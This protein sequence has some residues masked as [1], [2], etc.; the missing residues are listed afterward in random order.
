MSDIDDHSLNSGIDEGRD[1]DFDTE[2]VE[3]DALSEQEIK[4]L[5]G[6][7]EEQPFTD[8]TS[9]DEKPKKD[10]LKSRKKAQKG[11]QKA[12]RKKE[13]PVQTDAEHLTEETGN[14]GGL[15]DLRN[16]LP[17]NN[18]I[19]G[20]SFDISSNPDLRIDQEPDKKK[21]VTGSD[22]NLNVKAPVKH[23]ADTMTE[24]VRYEG[25]QVLPSSDNPDFDS[26]M[27]EEIIQPERH[28]GQ[29][30]YIKEISGYSGPD[31]SNIIGRTNNTPDIHQQK[32]SAYSTE[33][34]QKPDVTRNIAAE[35]KTAGNNV[36]LPASG[37]T[38][39]ERPETRTDDT[40]QVTS[41]T[42]QLNK[43]RNIEAKSQKDF[44][45]KSDKVLNLA[46]YT[47]R[48]LLISSVM[49]AAAD[50][51][52]TA[53]TAYFTLGTAKDSA[54]AVSA[55]LGLGVTDE[56]NVVLS[57]MGLRAAIIA[58]EQRSEAVS[59]AADK[60]RD[61]MD[62]YASADV[63]MLE[64]SRSDV[65]KNLN[66]VGIHK[67]SVSEKL[68][69]ATDAVKK[70]KEELE[71]AK[72]A[73]DEAAVK[74][75][76]ARLQSAN[77]RLGEAEKLKRAY[78]K[79]QKTFRMITKSRKDI[80]DAC[81]VKSDL[82]E[83]AKYSPNMFTARQLEHLQSK[84]FINGAVYSRQNIAVLNAYFKKNQ[85]LS[86]ISPVSMRTKDIKKL[87]KQSD[88]IGITVSDKRMLNMLIKM[89]KAEETKRLLGLK[90]RLG[91]RI[92]GI[93]AV[94]RLGIRMLDKDE[95]DSFR[96][97]KTTFRGGRVTGKMLSFASICG[98]KVIGTVTT[99]PRRYVR[100]KIQTVK[101][102]ART[103]V[104]TTGKAL[105]TTFKNSKPGKVVKR[106]IGRVKDTEVYPLSR[107]TLIF[108][109]VS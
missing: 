14:I 63:S 29:M 34:S 108:R 99:L 31:T 13:T 7:E 89:K 53:R 64:G 58:M 52:E 20:S 66:G 2:T 54:S 93:T 57:A 55:V 109:G 85:R 67:D 44:T 10:R 65:M 42:E 100:R 6:E 87:I 61:V 103:Q 72:Y 95:T 38:A 49:A 41:V 50:K 45:I 84:D 91:R 22:N 16:T 26:R 70:A 21:A 32:D 88:K 40:F 19:A 104:K 51:D 81:R 39:E 35:P 3:E 92:S 73:N 75:S 71:A 56:K 25:C 83:A 9:V 1:I 4:D 28:E 68:K 106:T 12:I 76:K 96:T 18:I 33:N 37:I 62:K 11:Q 97:V 23:T 90:S 69:S 27:E 78:N 17:E 60:L 102:I 47:G 8:D 36:M 48:E 5:L 94:G 79:E 59:R 30:P 107:T 80:L 74:L 82:L 86:D 24:S 46:S 101:N 105:N 98:V 77:T 43:C 15:S